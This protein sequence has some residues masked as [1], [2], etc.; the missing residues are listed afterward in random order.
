MPQIA[1]RSR[2][3][4]MLFLLLAV[5][6]CG[7]TD[8]RL[9]ELSERSLAR[10]AEQNQQM[11]RQSSEVA[12]ATRQLVEADAK[13]RQELITAQTQLQSELH[14][15]RTS[16]D[17]QHET[18][19]GERK[20]LAAQRHQEPIVAAAIVQAA[21]LLACV[22]PIV[23]CFLVVSALRRE[24]TSGVLEDMLILELTDPRSQ[25]LLGTRPPSAPPLPNSSQLP[26]LPHDINE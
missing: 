24:T 19:E 7:A 11:A 13:A 4:P 22:L 9:V 3:G 10:Q 14:T 15:E 26:S 23:L 8:D 17:R 12:K 6:G 5:A 2:S 20:E 25:L 1:H 16:L 21:T 18:L